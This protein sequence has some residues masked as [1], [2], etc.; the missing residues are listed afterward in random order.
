MKKQFF[1]PLMIIFILIIGIGLFLT[2][3]L[4]SALST[5][6]KLKGKILLQVESKGEAW[7]ISPVDGKRHY[8]G[9]PNDA[10]DL[11]RK[12]GIGVTN[13]NLNK[14]KIADE[15]LTGQDSDNDGLSDIVEDSI[16]TDKNN[17]DS[18]ADGYN[19]K[20]EIIAGY[21]PVGSG[22]LSLDDKF[23]RN[24]AG[25][26]L[27]QV[28]KHGEAW[29]VNPDNYQRYF[30]GRP[31]DAFNLMRK[32]GLGISNSNLVSIEQYINDDDLWLI[33]DKRQEA[34]KNKDVVAYNMVL[35]KPILS[36][37]VVQFNQTADLAYDI[38]TK[39]NKADF[40]NK[41][42]DDRQAIYSTNPKNIETADVYAYEQTYILFIKTG[43]LWKILPE[44]YKSW[45]VSKLGTYLTTTQ[46]EENSQAEEKLQAKMLDSDKDG[47]KDFYETCD[48][49][50]SSYSASCV[51]TDPN[52]RDTNGNGWWDGIEEK[53]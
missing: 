50:V 38:G 34:L 44:V 21:S 37:E 15:N 41:W 27:L 18:D 23:S 24:Q 26:I 22:K 47:L 39:L 10:F 16:G 43:G 6:S 2:A 33:F 31:I 36:N 8:M 13:D 20:D 42:Q 28:E 1:V 35:Y 25:K 19:D 12:L 5:P 11:M 3:E 4:A 17:Q 7:Y 9:R 29:Y 52:D 14:I 49:G 32:L 53:M 40:V 46:A 51:K 45:S 30:M 48:A